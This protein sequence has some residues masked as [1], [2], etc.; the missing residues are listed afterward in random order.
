VKTRFTS[1][2]LGRTSL[3]FIFN[4][5]E[6]ARIESCFEHGDRRLKLLTDERLYA[7]QEEIICT[8]FYFCVR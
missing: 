7:P 5:W 1:R 4:K 2:D 3:K 6:C 8:E